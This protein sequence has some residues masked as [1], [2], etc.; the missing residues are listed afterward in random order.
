MDLV[1]QFYSLGPVVATESPCFVSLPEL[2]KR[3]RSKPASFVET[4][5]W[6]R[7]CTATVAYRHG[8][9]VIAIEQTYPDHYGIM[10]AY[11]IAVDHAIE[12]CKNFDVGDASSLEVAVLLKVVDTPVQPGA[13]PRLGR[14]RCW[15]TLPPD[16][17]RHDEQHLLDYWRA[18]HP[19]VR[20]QIRRQMH[21]AEA[22]VHV[23]DLLVWSSIR[24]ENQKPLL[25]PVE[26]LLLPS[27][28]SATNAIA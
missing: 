20:N 26:G 2:G 22:V 8:H 19:E 9:K 28:N 18:D 1:N 14:R 5:Y 7:E 23:D 12:C 15:Q 13:Q 17:Y 6:L 16:W 4:I 25:A 11:D 21:R 3:P 27:D 24:S 10:T